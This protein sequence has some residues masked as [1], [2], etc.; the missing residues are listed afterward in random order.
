MRSEVSIMQE[1]LQIAME[2]AAKRLL[3]EKLFFGNQLCIF[4]IEPDHE[5]LVTQ[6]ENH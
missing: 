1:Y 3:I 2:D 5:Q 6:R 4:R